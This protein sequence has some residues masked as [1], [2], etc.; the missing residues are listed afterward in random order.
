MITLNAG[1]PNDPE[2]QPGTRIA[3][4]QAGVRIGG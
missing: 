1:P 4:A 3:V 2:P